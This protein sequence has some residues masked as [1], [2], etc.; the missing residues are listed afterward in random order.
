MRKVVSNYLIA[1]Q[2]A[3][4]LH[5]VPFKYILKC[6]LM[7]EC[8][9][10][11]TQLKIFPTNLQVKMQKRLNEKIIMRYICFFIIKHKKQ[12]V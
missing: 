12:G 1:T 9:F 5:S 3:Q 10:S 4:E 11:F 7:P 6:H 2:N 8:S